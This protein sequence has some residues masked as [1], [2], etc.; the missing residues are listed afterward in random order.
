MYQRH[1]IKSGTTKIRH[2]VLNSI[3]DLRNL[4]EIPGLIRDNNISAVWDDTD[5]MES[6][7]YCQSSLVTPAP[8]GRWRHR[9]DQRS[10]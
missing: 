8:H 10:G 1:W 4:P 5:P 7:P 3:K 9:L 6:E 2:V